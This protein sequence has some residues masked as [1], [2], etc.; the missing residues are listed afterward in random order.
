MI[1]LVD[2]ALDLIGARHEN[3]NVALGPVEILRDRLRGKLPR[4]LIVRLVP[5]VLDLDRIGAPFG[6]ECLAGGKV[7]FKPRTIEGR[8]HDDDPE[9]R[10]RRVLQV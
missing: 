9:I 8:G 5:Q 3:E 7:A 2:R 1:D 6:G 4:G 10:T